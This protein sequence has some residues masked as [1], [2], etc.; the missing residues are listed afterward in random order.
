MK[1]KHLLFFTSLM[2]ATLSGFSQITLTFANN[3]AVAGDVS[4]TFTADTTGVVPGT[5]GASQTWNFG[6]LV[7]GTTASTTNY[8]APSTTPYASS[9]P[10]A[11]VAA[12]TGANYEYFKINSSEYTVLGSYANSTSMIY[13]NTEKAWTYPYAY[14]NSSTDN[15]ACTYISSGITFYRTGT[16]TTIADGWG[17]LIMPNGAHN[18][19]RL[20]MVQDILDSTVS[21][22]NISFHIVTYMWFNGIDKTPL[23]EINIASENYMGTLF[24][25][26]SVSVSQSAA[27]INNYNN[28]LTA[29]NIFPNP[30]T[31]DVILT[32]A[33]KDAATAEISILDAQ[34][35][36]VKQISSNLIENSSNQI[37]LDIA[38]L[39]NG[40][41]FVRVSTP[42]GISYKKL[43]KN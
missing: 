39:S 40:I 27:G 28:E 20:K 26:K 37:T 10:S 6:S 13:S 43:I 11:T 7:I 25:S 15:F 3:G 33:S 18:T 31:D 29:L 24:N 19:L 17:S 30:T 41:Y 12:V 4:T 35:K 8:V 14:T 22:G 42:K 1:T 9:F 21:S 16:I 23:L 32:V 2:L 34:G 38:D 36:A 5:S